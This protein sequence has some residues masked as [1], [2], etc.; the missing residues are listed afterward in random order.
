MDTVDLTSRQA[1]YAAA[2]RIKDSRVDIL[3]NN[4]GL[5]NTKL[6]MET[7]DDRISRLIDVNTKAHFWVSIIAVYDISV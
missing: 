1:I 3:V 6:F 4:A 7:D 2:E 5:I